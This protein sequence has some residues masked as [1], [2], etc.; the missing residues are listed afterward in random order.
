M[1]EGEYGAASFE[2]TSPA[3]GLRWSDWF[4]QW[5]RSITAV[6][7]CAI[8][9]WIISESSF[10][11][12]GRTQSLGSRGGAEFAEQSRS[13]PRSPRLRVSNG[14]CGAPRIRM[15]DTPPCLRASA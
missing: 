11:G 1:S 13:P 12:I 2:I 4:G 3:P 6:M 15:L 14:A 9:P 8:L 10:A 5:E 7:S